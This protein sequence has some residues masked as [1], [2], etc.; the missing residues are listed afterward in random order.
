MQDFF[1]SCVE[2]FHGTVIPVM[3][4]ILLYLK[5]TTRS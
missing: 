1:V 5:A 2:W 4:L 3:I